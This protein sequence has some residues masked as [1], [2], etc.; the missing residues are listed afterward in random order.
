MRTKYLEKKTKEGKT[1]ACGG[2]EKVNRWVLDS[3]NEEKTP[4][5]LKREYKK[6]RRSKGLA[7]IV[8]GKARRLGGRNVNVWTL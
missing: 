2:D 1:R 6:R 4:T 5:K 8:R 7:E 3:R